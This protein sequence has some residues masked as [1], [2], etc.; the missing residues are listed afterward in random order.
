MARFLIPFILLS[1]PA[2]AD[3]GDRWHMMNWGYGMGMMFGPILWLVVIG[4]IVAGI[5]WMIRRNDDSTSA[6][7]QPNSQSK[8]LD[9]L[10]MRLANGEIDAEEYTE[11]RK[12]LSNSR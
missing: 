10:D 8:A 5:V 2:L 4:L 7:D 3:P 6:L 12:L 9:V 1:T 11:R